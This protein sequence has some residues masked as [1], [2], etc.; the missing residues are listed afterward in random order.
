VLEEALRDAIFWADSDMQ[1]RAFSGRG[2]KWLETR[3]RK[4]R[5]ALDAA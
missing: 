3:L 1:D 4:L 5:K 2:V